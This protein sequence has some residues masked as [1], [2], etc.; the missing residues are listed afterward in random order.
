MPCASSEGKTLTKDG[1]NTTK[2][3]DTSPYDVGRIRAV[4]L[5]KKPGGRNCLTRLEK[6]F[7]FFQEAAFLP[8]S[9]AQR[10]QPPYGEVSFVSDIA[11]RLP[12]LPSP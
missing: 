1:V 10:R 11:E 6:L 4:T 2:G 9:T 8:T 5:S 12:E 7:A 3:L